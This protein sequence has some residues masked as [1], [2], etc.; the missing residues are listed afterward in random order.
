[1]ELKGKT[2][3]VTD[4][5][6]GIGEGIAKAVAREGA[7]VVVN[8]RS[9][10]GA[11]AVAS[12]I[13]REGGSAI[14]YHADV[15][16]ADGLHTMVD[17]TV[18]R[19]GS[20]DILV[21]NAGIQSTPRLL[22][23]ITRIRICSW[24]RNRGV[25]SVGAPDRNII[26]VRLEVIGPAAIT[27]LRRQSRAKP[28]I[29]LPSG[30]SDAGTR[31][32]VSL[33]RLRDCAQPCAVPNHKQCPLNASRRGHRRDHSRR[34]HRRD[35]SLRGHRRDSSRQGHVA[36]RDHRRDSGIRPGCHPNRGP[37]SRLGTIA[38]MAQ[39]EPG[40]RWPLLNQR[41]RSLKK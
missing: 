8:N 29:F 38:G 16:D 25:N 13:A 30:R 10:D 4:A 41:V 14:A 32:G 20:V 23:D 11:E 19:F 34:G 37:R 40:P 9:L 3:I 17:A 35:H 5:G 22:K 2:A 24:L 15:T 7:N 12:A 39:V 18:D 36:S 28:G 27:D 26:R 6:R 31:I 33:L 21:N 1:M